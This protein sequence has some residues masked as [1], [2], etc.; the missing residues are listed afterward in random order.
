MVITVNTVRIKKVGIHSKCQFPRQTSVKIFGDTHLQKRQI[1]VA[2][3]PVV[4]DE[5]N[6]KVLSEIKRLLVS[7]F[8][9]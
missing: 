3:W 6:K 4:T 7:S 1:S 8:L 9:I 5:E 2:K